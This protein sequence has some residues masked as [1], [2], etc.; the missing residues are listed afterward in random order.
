M[1]KQATAKRRKAAPKKAPA[2][3]KV[4]PPIVATD[5]QAEDV[6]MDV[7]MGALKRAQ[8][9]REDQAQGER[10]GVA[11]EGEDAFTVGAWITT[12]SGVMVD[13]SGI[14][15]PFGKN[16]DPKQVHHLP[17]LPLQITRAKLAD[18]TTRLYVDVRFM[19][20]AGDLQERR[21]TSYELSSF[22]YDRH[23]MVQAGWTPPHP[24]AAGDVSRALS[25]L[26]RESSSIPRK[27][28]YEACGWV[29]DGLHIRPG[30]PDYVGVEKG[31]VGTTGD[32]A[33]W[34][35][36]QADLI[37]DCPALALGTA[38]L[39]SS[40]LRGVVS[41][42]HH[43]SHYFHIFGPGSKGKTTILH[44]LASWAGAPHKPNVLDSESTARG[45]EGVM[46]AANH[47]WV[48]LDEIDAILGKSNQPGPETLMFLSNGGGRVT[49]SRGRVNLLGPT[50]SSHIISTG[51]ASM[52]ALASGSPKGAAL[53]TRIFETDIM[54][55]DLGSFRGPLLDVFAKLG[56]LEKN[57]GWGY[58]AAIDYIKE[59][60]A[61]LEA[62]YLT[63]QSE[64]A[65]T[66]TLARLFEDQARLLVFFALCMCGADM[67]G[68]LV[69]K[70]AGE[71]CHRAV[72]IA[73]ERYEQEPEE[74][75]DHNAVQGFQI[76]ETVKD[77]VV[78]NSG[79]FMWR[80]F[81]W[82]PSKNQQAEA[83][84]SATTYA[85][86][87]S[88]GALGQMEQ[89]RAM[90]H[91]ADLE[92]TLTLSPRALDELEK[93][94]QVSRA[95][96]LDAAKLYGVLL[97]QA[98]R[99]DVKLSRGLAGALGGSRGLRLSLRPLTLADA[100]RPNRAV[101]LPSKRHHFLQGLPGVEGGIL[102]WWDEDTM[103]PLP[104][105]LAGRQLELAGL[106]PND[107]DHATTK[108]AIDE[109]LAT[110]TIAGP[111]TDIEKWTRTTGDNSPESAED[112]HQDTD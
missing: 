48:L 40:L 12:P 5:D 24:R 85:T 15:G 13:N 55:T 59:H 99:T 44:C 81:A 88:N 93:R 42:P 46:G 111:V 94:E 11:K 33:V 74:A 101:K 91:D 110:A 10:L 52:I 30:H 26:I 35:K 20:I 54:D 83:A 78:R 29:A 14:W 50:W 49:S 25:M 70:E 76:L 95:E 89:S 79:R 67:V 102:E 108:R 4:T 61:E 53:A 27:E 71:A 60:R 1:A 84:K 72:E 66:P 86:G 58:P 109:A 31:A 41:L 63:Y 64:L 51:N 104:P 34:R 97:T 45:L 75:T 65:E 16:G 17:V 6:P 47:G 87:S 98:G 96:L 107:P 28:G 100:E 9:E 23:P 32:A 22:N 19:T 105:E 3:T 103:G 8:D 37:T 56:N 112:L 62:S 82:H 18:G 43:T 38:F 2:T 39:V 106:D 21:V 57:Y 68:A 7:D 77:F 69:S 80:G 36:T 92:G 90:A 73:L